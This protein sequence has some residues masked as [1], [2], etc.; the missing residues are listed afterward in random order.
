VTDPVTV[1]GHNVDAVAQYTYLGSIL[2][3]DGDVEAE[4]S[5]RIGNVVLVFQHM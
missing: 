4:V 3:C 2:T 5:C 1:G